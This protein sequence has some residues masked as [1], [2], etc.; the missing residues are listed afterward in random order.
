MPKTKTKNKN[1]NNKT[2]IDTYVSFRNA[3]QCK[4]LSTDKWLTD[5]SVQDQASSWQTMAILL[6]RRLTSTNKLIADL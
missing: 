3:P 4:E 6:E 1:K 2:I 5:Q